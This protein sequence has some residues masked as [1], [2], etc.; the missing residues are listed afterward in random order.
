MDTLDHKNI[1]KDVPYFKDKVRY[2]DI[3]CLQ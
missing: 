1:D 2:M 3:A